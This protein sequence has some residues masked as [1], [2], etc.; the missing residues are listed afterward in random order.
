MRK[1]IFAVVMSLAL[2]STFTIGASAH[3]AIA[4][5]RVSHVVPLSTGGGCDPNPKKSFS[6]DLQNMRA[7]ISETDLE[8]L[9]PDAYVDF[10]TANIHGGIS[11]CEAGV[12]LFDT[13]GNLITAGPKI[14]C[15]KQAV[16]NTKNAHF[17]GYYET[18]TTGSY[19]SYAFV[20]VYY[21]NGGSSTVASRSPNIYL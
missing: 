17:I 11:S 14:D 12:S 3:S 7:C 10:Y 4:V 15:M 8:I 21:N 5:H 9:K 2:L 1:L 16:S 13:S 6:G 18:F 19:Y 20:T